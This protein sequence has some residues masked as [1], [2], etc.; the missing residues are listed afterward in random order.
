[1]IHAIIRRSQA[2]DPKDATELGV[3]SAWEGACASS[4]M[5]K[6]VDSAFLRVCHVTL[7]CEAAGAAVQ[8]DGIGWLHKSRG[9]HVLAFIICC[10]LGK[11][12]RWE[13][14]RKN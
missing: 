5:R 6:R 10:V 11:S 1:M 13:L 4:W 8:K 2:R 3:L 9:K 14:V 12:W 7:P